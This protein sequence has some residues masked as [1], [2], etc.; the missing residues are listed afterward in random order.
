MDQAEDNGLNL[1]DVSV[2]HALQPT[3]TKDDIYMLYIIYTP[4][5]GL[6]I[7]VSVREREQDRF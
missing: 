2:I 5:S 4:N 6:A 7:A 3:T 1:F